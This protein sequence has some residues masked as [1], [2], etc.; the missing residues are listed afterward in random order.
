MLMK[1]TSLHTT[2]AAGPFMRRRR[3]GYVFLISVLA[4]GAIATATTI[5]MLLLGLAAQQSGFTILQSTQALEY[6]HTCVERALLELRTD[7]Y[8]VGEKTFTFTYGSCVLDSIGGANNV[9]RTICAE[10]YSGDVVRRVEVKVAKLLP[11]TTIDT[12]REVENFTYCR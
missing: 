8:Y 5:S 2:C 1:L 11:T 7:P 12:W 9:N 6:A 3:G 10:G 4:I